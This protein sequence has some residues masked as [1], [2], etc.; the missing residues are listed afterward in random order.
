MLLRLFISVEYLKWR[1]YIMVYCCSSLHS[2]LITATVAVFVSL[3]KYFTFIFWL[4]HAACGILVPRPGI[5]PGS[6][7]MRTRSPNHWTNRWFLASLKLY[8]TI[9]QGLICGFVDYMDKR[10]T[11]CSLQVKSILWANNGFYI[12]WWLR[13]FWDMRKFKLQWSQTKLCW[14]TA[15]CICLHTWLFSHCHG[16]AE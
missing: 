5:E 16:R 11:H 15:L 6:L 4:H 2:S 7:A 12:V 14:N 9:Q 13:I 10:L 8:D 3:K 1:S